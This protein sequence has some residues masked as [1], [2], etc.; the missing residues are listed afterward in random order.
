MMGLVLP[1]MFDVQLPDRD[2][3][4]R[5]FTRWEQSLPSAW[6]KLRHERQQ[7]RTADRVDA[8]SLMPQSSRAFLHTRP[9]RAEHDGDRRGHEEVGIVEKIRAVI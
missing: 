8:A 5:D 4:I 6:R 1:P 7:Q 2:W 3:M 9:R